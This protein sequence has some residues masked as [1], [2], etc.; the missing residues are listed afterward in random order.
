MLGIM[1]T[2]VL[3]DMWRANGRDKDTGAKVAATS[4]IGW[5]N[6]LVGDAQGVWMEAP[7]RFG[8]GQEE[9]LRSNK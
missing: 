3:S 7:Y 5:V 4:V 9:C 1:H 8:H 2:Y 6:R